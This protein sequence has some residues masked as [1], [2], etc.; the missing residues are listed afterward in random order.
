[1]LARTMIHVTKDL[2]LIER[3]TYE[4]VQRTLLPRNQPKLLGNAKPSLKLNEEPL[5]SIRLRNATTRS[6][7]ERVNRS[8]MSKTNLRISIDDAGSKLHWP[9]HVI[10]KRLSFS[11]FLNTLPLISTNWFDT[12]S[13]S[14]AWSY[15]LTATLRQ[16]IWYIITNVW[17]TVRNVSVDIQHDIHRRTCVYQRQTEEEKRTQCIRGRSFTVRYDLERWPWKQAIYDI[18]SYWTA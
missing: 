1:M 6:I 5:S 15:E 3:H 13:V 16:I 17:D 2:N 4:I 9:A 7:N 12:S 11:N 18:L 8:T 14:N 10:W